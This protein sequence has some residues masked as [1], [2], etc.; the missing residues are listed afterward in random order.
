[1]SDS[2]NQTFEMFVRAAWGDLIGDLAESLE[3]ALQILN[4]N[5]DV[6]LSSGSE[7]DVSSD[8]AGAI[9][10]RTWV[11][12][13]GSGEILGS[14]AAC[15]SN[16][17][18]QP[19]LFSLAV[20][21]GES[22]AAD[23]DL[24]QMTTQLSQSYDEINLL[25]RFSRTLSPDEGFAFTAQKLLEETAD[26]LEQRPL[27]LCRPE[28]DHVEWSAGANST[29]PESLHWL[30][31]SK[32]ALEAIHLEIIRNRRDGRSSNSSR[33]SGTVVLPQGSIHYVASPVRVKDKVTGYVGVFRTKAENPFETGEL[34]VLECLADELSN[35]A[36][37]RHLYQELREMLFSTVK[38]LV[39][40]IDAKDE[41][42][43]GHSERVYRISI[44]IGER[45][46]LS[47]EEMQTLSWSALLHDVGKIA[48]PER[49][50]NKPT[51]LTDEEFR[52]IQI[53]P[54]R[55]CRVLRHIPQ[56]RA[57]LPAI[58]HHHERYDGKGYPSGMK[59]EDIPLLARILAVADTYDAILS[60]RAYRPPQALD[61]AL[62]EI[63]EGA[64]TQFDPRAAAVFLELAAEG[65]FEDLESED[66]RKL[67]A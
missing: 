8:R 50:L 60:A 36:T 19:L 13:E 6:I 27:I 52:A 37:R 5:G 31:G 41:Y 25:Y 2:L 40:A 57:S 42:T 51:K 65:A 48:V 9:L 30:T 66:I 64:G 56:L 21:I 47:A 54:E 23:R 44:R 20:R 22:F 24:D 39:A 11:P 10:E 29:F 49:I 46:G 43:R 58:R 67:A 14:L 7:P 4:P 55:G 18:L 28:H 15:S 45:L 17:R 53:H 16:P 1:M 3:T 62:N 32:D 63:R 35:A 61:F 59:G 33:H 34:R 38:S 12:I 26:L